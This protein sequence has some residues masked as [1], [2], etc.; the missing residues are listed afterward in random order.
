MVFP[1]SV[2]NQCFRHI[3]SCRL[4]VNKLGQLVMVQTGQNVGEILCRRYLMRLQVIVHGF[5][6]GR[7]AEVLVRKAWRSPVGRFRCE[8]WDYRITVPLLIDLNT[9]YASS[10]K[11]STSAQLPFPAKNMV[12][13]FKNSRYPFLVD[14]HRSLLVEAIYSRCTISAFCIDSY[15]SKPSPD[16]QFR[17]S[18][19]RRLRRGKRIIADTYRSGA[20]MITFRYPA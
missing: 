13:S 12:A 3:E 2:L 5:I 18:G 15:C 9:N 1:N 8:G 11:P 20:F 10:D 7:Q 16:T 19:T 4:C 14:L 6:V 17:W